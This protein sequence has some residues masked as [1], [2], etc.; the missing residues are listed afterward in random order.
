MADMNLGTSV[1]A[2][3]RSQRSQNIILTSKL[4]NL[5]IQQKRLIQFQK[6][7]I[8]KNFEYWFR[9]YSM[10]LDVL[11]T[12]SNLDDRQIKVASKP[13]DHFSEVF[14]MRMTGCSSD[15]V[16]LFIGFRV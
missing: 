6:K 2:T 11:S 7:N 5:H 10:N 8:T 15:P 12:I 14:Y 1:S 16:L 4:Y 3:T 9:Q 13:E